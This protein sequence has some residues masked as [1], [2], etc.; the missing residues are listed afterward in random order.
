MTETDLSQYRQ[1]ISPYRRRFGIIA[2]TALGVSTAIGIVAWLVGIDG[3][4]WWLL[5]IRGVLTLTAL[6]A[7]VLWLFNVGATRGNA[8]SG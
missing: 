8:S 4:A 6:T 1:R 2:F 7:G 5:A 3:G